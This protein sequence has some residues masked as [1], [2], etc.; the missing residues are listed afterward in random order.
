VD[1]GLIVAMYMSKMASPELAQGCPQGLD[2][3][4]HDCR[5]I[6][7]LVFPATHGDQ[8]CLPAGGVES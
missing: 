3:A 1:T 8:E 7:E 4:D 6:V 2:Y 5:R